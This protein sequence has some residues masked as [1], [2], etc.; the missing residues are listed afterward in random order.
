MR[1][2]PPRT[3]AIAALVAIV[4]LGFGLNFAYQVARKPSELFFPVSGSLYKTPSAT[5]HDYR[6][7][8]RGHATPTI[9][10]DLLAA[11]AQVEG[12]GNPVARTAW[13][14]SLRGKAFDLYRPSSSAVGMLQITDA[15][16]AD[17][18]RYC[19]HDHAVAEDGPWH[20]WDSCWLNRLYT[21]TLPSHAVELTSAYLDRSVTGMLRRQRIAEPT[22]AQRQDLAA[23]IHLCGAGTGERYA[24]RGF[25]LASGQRC[26]DHDVQAYL[27]RVNAMRKVF[28]ALAARD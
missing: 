24:R 26:G 13:R 12:A 1:H 4:L 28:R 11:L 19:I 2:L 25:R 18:R 16:F 3:Q 15:A 22:L 14:W 23:V 27:T 17:A 5:W 10:A 21:R 20:D 6:H 8:F 7:I 9:P